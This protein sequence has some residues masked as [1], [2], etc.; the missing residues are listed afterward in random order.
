[1]KWMMWL[2]LCAVCN[3]NGQ[4]SKDTS[5]TVITPGQRDQVDKLRSELNAAFEAGEGVPVCRKSN[6]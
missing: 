5:K 1:M 2:V 4:K 6:T 3:S